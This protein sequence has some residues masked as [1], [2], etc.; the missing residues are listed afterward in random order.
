[1]PESGFSVGQ[2]SPRRVGH[3]CGNIFSVRP[4]KKMAASI[5]GVQPQLL[6]RS[7]AMKINCMQYDFGSAY[8]LVSLFT[9]SLSRKI[10]V[11]GF[12][13]KFRQ[14]SILRMQNQIQKQK[15]EFHC[16][17]AKWLIVDWI[18]KMR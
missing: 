16:G 3:K 13:S 7:I 4:Q 11:A 17:I 10:C 1:M 15:Y 14:F 5:G 9:K 18:N 8:F 2:E 6:F 12:L